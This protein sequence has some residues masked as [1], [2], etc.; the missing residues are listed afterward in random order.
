MSVQLVQAKARV[1]SL[2]K[3]TINRIELMA[4]TIGA[5]LGTSNQRLIGREIECVYWSDSTTVLAWIKQND[6]WGTFVGNR[7]REI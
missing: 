2:K 5:R 4:S 6:E 7:V 1:A 3:A